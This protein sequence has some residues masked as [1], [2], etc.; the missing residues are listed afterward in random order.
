MFLAPITCTQA[1][2]RSWSR[3]TPEAQGISSQAVCGFGE[4]LKAI[5]TIP[6]FMIKRHGHV[7]RQDDGNQRR[8]TNRTIRTR[9]GRVLHRLYVANDGHYLYTRFTLHAA[10]D[11]FTWQQNIFMDADNHPG[12][13][14]GA[15]GLG[16]EVLIQ[17]G[18]YQEKH[19]GFNEG[20]INGLGWLAAPTGAGTQFELRIARAATYASDS[21]PVFSGDTIAFVLAS[22]A[23][24][25]EWSPTTP[26]VYTFE[27]ALA[28]LTTNLTLVGFA[29]SAWQANAAGSDLGTNWLEQSYD[30]TQ[31]GQLDQQPHRRA[32]GV[33]GQSPARYLG[34][35]RF[36][37]SDPREL[38]LAGGRRDRQLRW[39]LQLHFS[40]PSGKVRGS[41]TTCFTKWRAR[42]ALRRRVGPVHG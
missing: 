25:N 13:G 16:S 35:G 30:D 24:P 27:S 26:M 32:D 8:R 18:G 17:G 34:R 22:D 9:S 10:A 28:A 11:P 4:A 40:R 42:R 33:G 14:S 21:T 19:G 1:V 7:T 41:E 6:N 15:N 23:T 36:G 38:F 37:Q 31:A 29:N 20:D 39:Q 12:T 2:N 3:S 5:H